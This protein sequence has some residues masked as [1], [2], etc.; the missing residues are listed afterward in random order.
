MDRIVQLGADMPQRRQ[1]YPGLSVAL[2]DEAAAEE[3]EYRRTAVL[4]LSKR[5]QQV[6]NPA[7]TSRHIECI[8]GEIR[9]ALN[10]AV[11]ASTDPQYTRQVETVTNAAAV[12]QNP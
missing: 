3:L 10:L 12:I 9:E 2:K 7:H 11:K 5:V 4:E 1:H 8:L 6:T